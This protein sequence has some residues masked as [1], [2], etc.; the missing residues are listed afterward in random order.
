MKSK[1]RWIFYILIGVSFGIFDWFYLDWLATGVAPRL[2]ENRIIAILIITLM[3]YGIW[4]VPIIPVVIYEAK[5]APTIKGPIK[6]G[7]LTWCC[8]LLSYYVLYAALL[9]LGKLP[10]MEGFYVFGEQFESFRVQYWMVLRNI[11]LFQL[12]EWL[13]I[14]IIGGGITGAL[15]WWIF[16]KRLNKTDPS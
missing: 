2:I 6:A 4:L 3:N 9:S 15:A 13:P 5:H 14:G 1:K 11:V 10:H 12:L 16:S 7:I 8:A